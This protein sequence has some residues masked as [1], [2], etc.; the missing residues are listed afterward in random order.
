MLTYYI[1]EYIRS[2]FPLRTKHKQSSL[3][4]EMG[5]PCSL[6]KKIMQLWRGWSPPWLLGQ[7]ISEYIRSSI[8]KQS[9]SSSQ[10]N[11]ALKGLIATLTFRTI[12]IQIQLIS[13]RTK[14]R[15]SSLISALR[16]RSL[17]SKPATLKGL[18]ATLIFRTI[19]IQIQLFSW[20]LPFNPRRDFAAHTATHLCFKNEKTFFNDI[21][22][23]LYRGEIYI[24][25]LK[26]SLFPLSPHGK[27]VYFLG[28]SLSIT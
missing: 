9:V 26:A 8:S 10:K 28:P 20:F 4:F 1:F 14:R 18:I 12:Y 2:S 23:Q 3:I 6:K 24:S 25:C 16:R 19:Y 13:L 22:F 15:Q 11:E 17:L 21:L 7:Y 5:G 27:N